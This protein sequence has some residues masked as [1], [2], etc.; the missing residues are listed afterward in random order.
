MRQVG[1][2]NFTLFIELQ[3]GCGFGFG[4]SCLFAWKWWR[5]GRR[6]NLYECLE[7]TS[8][9]SL[10]SVH[11]PIH[12]IML[13]R[14]SPSFKKFMSFCVVFRVLREREKKVDLRLK[15]IFNGWIFLF[16]V[17]STMKFLK[18][19]LNLSQFFVEY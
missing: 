17:R 18:F 11:N 3:E 5:W 1:I 8:T 9:L 16:V 4:C 14:N 13:I 2:H 7:S 15:F 12:L 19:H 10:L 6:K